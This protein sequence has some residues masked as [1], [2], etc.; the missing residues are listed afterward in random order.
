MSLVAPQYAANIRRPIP[1]FNMAGIKTVIFPPPL[2]PFQTLPYDVIDRIIEYTLDGVNSTNKKFW[3]KSYP[4]MQCCR[5]WRIAF[6]Q[7]E[8][9]VMTVKL[10]RSLPLGLSFSKHPYPANPRLYPIKECVRHLVF[11]FESWK[12]LSAGETLE[13][14]RSSVEM[15]RINKTAVSSLRIEGFYGD[16]WVA[17]FKKNKDAAVTRLVELLTYLHESFPNITSVSLNILKWE[18]LK[19]V[20]RTDLRV[21]KALA[22]LFYGRDVE[23]FAKFVK[24]SFKTMNPRYFT[25]ITS[26]RIESANAHNY[27]KYSEDWVMKVIRLNAPT[28]RKLH[29]CAI[30]DELLK[31]LTTSKAGNQMTYPKLRKIT[32]RVNCYGSNAQRNLAQALARGELLEHSFRHFPALKYI[33]LYGRRF[34]THLS[35]SDSDEAEV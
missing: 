27:F 11:K 21:E 15:G 29:L 33:N 13:W 22:A 28:L 7:T 17:Y 24:D 26:L 30:S 12:R 18:F 14:L 8:F 20:D 19:Y 31:D 25:G 35:T 23:M 2:S 34:E 16:E 9:S 10:K 6:I 1:P 4:L 3:R 32:T 5:N